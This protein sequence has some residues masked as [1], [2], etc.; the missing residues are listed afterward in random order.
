MSRPRLSKEIRFL[1][2]VRLVS[3]YKGWAMAHNLSS[4]ILEVAMT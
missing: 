1:F 3:Y 2:S 4:G